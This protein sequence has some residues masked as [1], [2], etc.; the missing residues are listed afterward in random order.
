MNKVCALVESVV[1]R[2]GKLCLLG[3]FNFHFGDEYLSGV[4]KYR[5]LLDSFSVV[6]HVQ[7]PT[8]QKGHLFDLINTRCH[9]KPTT[10]GECKLPTAI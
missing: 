6:Q 7:G 9:E 3:D 1:V 2:S 10:S 4:R 8:R 5:D